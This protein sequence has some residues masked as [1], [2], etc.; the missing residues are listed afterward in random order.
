MKPIETLQSETSSRPET[1]MSQLSGSNWMHDGQ[2]NRS[3]VG[4]TSSTPLNQAKRA[5]VLS[6]QTANSA[7]FTS[8]DEAR[9]SDR[10]DLTD[11]AIALPAPGSQANQM[12]PWLERA[13][14]G[15]GTSPDERSFPGGLPGLFWDEP[16]SQA[17]PTP[18]TPVTPTAPKAAIATAPTKSVAD[19]HKSTV[20]YESAADLITQS[21]NAEKGDARDLGDSAAVHPE[22]T[23]APIN[24]Q[25]LAPASPNAPLSSTTMAAPS[26][27]TAQAMRR[28][29]ELVRDRQPSVPFTEDIAPMPPAKDVRP[30]Q[31]TS[32]TVSFN[33][34]R[35]ADPSSNDSS[36]PPPADSVIPPPLP[37][38]AIQEPSTFHARHAHQRSR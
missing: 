37:S 8:G 3:S 25:G 30:A 12:R 19:V 15:Y 21:S 27:E 26:D 13:A 2:G 20:R 4:T 14:S 5:S 32:S 34:P 38:D 16:A 22:S 33:S 23:L 35:G 36:S 9:A 18:V 1:A 7:G 28:S 11:D 24:T 31:P 10:E 29:P 6:F 17:P